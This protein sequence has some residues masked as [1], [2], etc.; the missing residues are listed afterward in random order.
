MA[1]RRGEGGVCG[2]LAGGLG[3]RVEY[4][5][6]PGWNGRGIEVVQCTVRY[7]FEL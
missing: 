1:K 2:L 5:L 3:G 4:L 6:L 7:V